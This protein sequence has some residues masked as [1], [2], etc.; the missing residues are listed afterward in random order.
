MTRPGEVLSGKTI[1]AIIWIQ[2]VAP[3]GLYKVFFASVPGRA[4]K[5]SRSYCFTLDL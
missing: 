5:I 1:V 3:I 2:S 4:T